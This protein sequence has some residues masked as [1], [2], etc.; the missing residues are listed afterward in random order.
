M[1]L[2]IPGRIVEFAAE[3]SFAV[4][5]VTGV[6]RKVNV[7]LLRPDGLAVDDW[8]LIHVGFA[9]SRISAEQAEEQLRLLTMLGEATLAAEE[10]EGYQFE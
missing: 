1:C 7:D 6:R 10:V 9:M 5:D 2:A 4:V 3:P 8:V